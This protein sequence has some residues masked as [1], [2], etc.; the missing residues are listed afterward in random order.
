VF[1]HPIRWLYI[2]PGDASFAT[3]SGE[4]RMSSFLSKIKGVP[5]NLPHGLTPSRGLK[6]FALDKGERAGMALAL[7]AAKGY[8]YDKLVF[9]GVGI[10][11]W[12][13]ALGYIGSAI[14]GGNAHLER[15]GDVGMTAYLYMLGAD[16]GNSKS[17]R[18]IVVQQT[19]PKGKQQVVGVIPPRGSGAFLS[20]EE[21][22]N[23]AGPR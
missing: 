14:L 3:N 6:G 16:W 18:S 1:W 20:A 4:K 17:K 22:A 19:L 23:S 13:G 21:I 8:W 11:A 15:A 7:G 2:H 12:V 5:G 10:E 9:K